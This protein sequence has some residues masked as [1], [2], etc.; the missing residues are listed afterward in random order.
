M[1]RIDPPS[2]ADLRAAYATRTIS[3]MARL[4]GVGR[5]TVCKWLADAGIA[6]RAAAPRQQQRKFNWVKDYLDD[7]AQRR[8]Q[9]RDAGWPML[10]ELRRVE[11]FQVG[12][13]RVTRE[14]VG[15]R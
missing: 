8:Q 3:D 11:V 14:Y 10:G 4:Y 15:L 9:E 13:V 12:A 5:S 6:S 1:Q 7:Q 2:P